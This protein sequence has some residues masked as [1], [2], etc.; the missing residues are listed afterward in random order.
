[1]SGLYPNPLSDAYP[2]SFSLITVLNQREE[3]HW[4]P[5]GL[6]P[7]DI[8]PWACEEAGPPSDL[9][10]QATCRCERARGN[11]REFHTLRRFRREF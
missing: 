11:V 3:R 7:P 5:H 2:L 6:I 10:R 1:V 9:A 8:P 4:L